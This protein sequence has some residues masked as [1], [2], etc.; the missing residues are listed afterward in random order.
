MVIHSQPVSSG[1]SSRAAYTNDHRYT[2]V[3]KLHTYFS[4][5][6]CD[7]YIIGEGG[8]NRCLGVISNAM[9]KHEKVILSMACVF[10]MACNII[11]T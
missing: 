7:M 3:W 1:W 5:V 6:F 2:S 9:D 8:G 11:A 4:H 10:T